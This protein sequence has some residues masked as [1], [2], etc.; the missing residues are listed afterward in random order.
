MAIN[1]N[2]L[3]DSLGLTRLWEYIN[4]KLSNKVESDLFQELVGNKPVSEQIKDVVG[5]EIITEITYDEI[6]EI[7]GS[8]VSLGDKTVMILQDSVTKE[9]YNLGMQNGQLI[10]YPMEVSDPERPEDE[11]EA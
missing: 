2:P 7:C 1:K 5:N 4:I 8:T 11:E 3:L 6:D 10:S 9:Y